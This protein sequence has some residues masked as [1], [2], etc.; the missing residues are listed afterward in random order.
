VKKVFQTGAAALAFAVLCGAAPGPQPPQTTVAK[1]PATGPNGSDPFL[2]LEDKDG[3][4][5]M[6]WVH[7]QNARSLPVLQR[8]PH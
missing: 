4:R 6:A 2:W 3:A 5:A 7:A 8:D 1:A